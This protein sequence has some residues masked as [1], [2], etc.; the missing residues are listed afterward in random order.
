MLKKAKIGLALLAAAVTFVEL[1]DK[2]YQE[3]RKE[4]L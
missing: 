2:L 4:G 3:C 1:A